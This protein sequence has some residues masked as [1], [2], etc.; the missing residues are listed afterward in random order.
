MYGCAMAKHPTYTK[1][2]NP[3]LKHARKLSSL[4]IEYLGGQKLDT[5][6][7][8]KDLEALIVEVVSA[9]ATSDL[10][11]RLVVEGLEREA[12][13]YPMKGETLRDWL[14]ES[15]IS[16][17][18]E[19]ARKGGSL[20]S[21]FAETVFGGELVKTVLG[22]ALS[23]LMTTFVSK[24]PLGGAA[25]SDAGGGK[26]SGLFGS[27][28]RAGASRLKEASSNLGLGALQET[29]EANAKEFA[30]QSTDRLRRAIGQRLTATEG[31]L[32]DLRVDILH[33]VLAF[34]VAKV[35][36]W[37]HPVDRARVVSA[38]HRT[39]T[40]ALESDELAPQRLRKH[41]AHLN[42]SFGETTLEAFLRDLGLWDVLLKHIEPWL[43][44]H[45][46]QLFK[47][48]SFEAWFV[49]LIGD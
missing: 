38:V 25:A 17:L 7:P 9:I 28:A 15:V 6:F 13:E 49:D 24:L 44:E 39:L 10:L 45:L 41:I 12:T 46:L 3:K 35:W 23:D 31:G 47:M 1:L 27:I 4:V 40:H 19:Q 18:E 36:T 20:P 22:G 14:P 43:E 26:S 33:L 37:S 8:P 42:D 16:D 21:E 11:E 32:A 48:K 30:M 34:D 29:L 2:K 5:L